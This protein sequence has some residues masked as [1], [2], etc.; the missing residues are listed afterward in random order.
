MPAACHIIKHHAKRKNIA[1][2]R[3]IGAASLFR[4]HISKGSNENAGIAVE[5]SQAYHSEVEH[6]H[7]PVVADHD[8]FRFQVS[9]ND[10]DLMCGSD[11]LGHLYG[12]VDEFFM[13][14]T[15]IDELP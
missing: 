11:R 12:V 13:P 5:S 4:R 1:R 2:L 14:N 9:M 8:V 10:A 6:F 3:D 15:R 7:I